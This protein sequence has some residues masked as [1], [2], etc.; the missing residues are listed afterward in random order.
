MVLSNEWKINSVHIT[1]L[2]GVLFFVLGT[3]GLI[4]I[5]ILEGL[6]EL[7]PISSTILILGVIFLGILIMK[8]KRSQK[9]I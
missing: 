4:Q 8:N 1:L 3:L 7:I 6:S 9:S 5:G 2:I